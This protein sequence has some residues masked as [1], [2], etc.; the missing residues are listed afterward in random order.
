MGGIDVE[1]FLFHPSPIVFETKT[2]SEKTKATKHK[3]DILIRQLY[4]AQSRFSGTN[5]AGWE[6]ER[7]EMAIF[8]TKSFWASVGK[9]KKVLRKFEE[10][11]F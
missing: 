6:N 11:R 7:N 2:K 9:A 1:V 4:F 10:G 5:A 8:T 3:N